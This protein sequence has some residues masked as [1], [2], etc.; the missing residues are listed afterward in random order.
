[1]V[2]EAKLTGS[3]DEAVAVTVNGALPNALFG[4]AL[5]VMV[6]LAGVTVKP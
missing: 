1:M 6:W 4:G 5:K 2:R 3:A